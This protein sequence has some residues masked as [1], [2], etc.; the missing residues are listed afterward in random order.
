M[1]ETETVGSPKIEKKIPPYSLEYEFADGILL[2]KAGLEV[3]DDDIAFLIDDISRIE[4]VR[5][6]GDM[7]KAIV[8]TRIFLDGVIAAISN[9]LTP[10][11]GK[12]LKFGLIR[13]ERDTGA[14]FHSGAAE[15]FNS[16]YLHKAVLLNYGL[17]ESLSLL[18]PTEY[19][20]ERD[21]DT[22]EI[23]YCGPVWYILRA[24]GIEEGDHA[25]WVL[26]GHR[27]S[28]VK[29]ENG[30]TMAQYCSSNIEYHALVRR[31]ND[32]ID[33]LHQME[34]SPAERSMLQ[35]AL[36]FYDKQI[37]GSKEIREKRRHEKNIR[38]T[39]TTVST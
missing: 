22:N 11:Q 2:N 7:D 15:V 34:L 29:M 28:G 23:T 32:A 5:F 36:G 14:V 18:E 21:V 20:E 13:R 27:G 25:A 30:M 17:I 33:I 3:T 26:T 4:G 6:Q 1:D 10:D 16:E 38:K 37:E 8:L 35:T 31:R 9:Q 24:V 39:L 12:Q 19:Y